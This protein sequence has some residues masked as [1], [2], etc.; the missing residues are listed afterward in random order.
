MVSLS[1][2]ITHRFQQVQCL[3]SNI[4]TC[5]IHKLHGESIC[6]LKTVLSFFLDP[7]IIRA[8]SD[9]LTSIQFTDRASHMPCSDL[10][11]GDSMSALLL[12]LGDE[13]VTTQTFYEGVIEF[14]IAAVKKLLK[15]FDFKSNNVQALSFLEPCSLKN[16]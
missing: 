11:I 4:Q 14:Y 1:F 13:G 8:H 16:N 9:D 2:Q 10:F 12:H 15:V 5:T 7:S 3:L 6:L